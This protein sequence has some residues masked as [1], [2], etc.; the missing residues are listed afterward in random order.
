MTRHGRSQWPRGLRRGSAH[1]RLLGLWVRIL[2]SVSVV[3]WQVEVSA[4]GRLLVQRSPAECGVSE[5]DLDAWTVSRPW[6]T[7]DCRTMKKKMTRHS[8]FDTAIRLLA[9]RLRTHGCLSGRGRNLSFLAVVE[10]N[11]GAHLFII[12]WIRG[13]FPGGKTAG[14]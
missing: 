2:S 5:C 9:E 8:P 4:T 10:T 14:E 1:A 13:L 3:C 12:H 6:P 11:S 7:R